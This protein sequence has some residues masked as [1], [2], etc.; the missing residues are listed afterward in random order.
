MRAHLVQAEKEKDQG[1]ERQVK[2]QN[3]DGKW[4]ERDRDQLPAHFR[5][6]SASWCGR[7]AQMAKNDR[8]HDCEI[9]EVSRV[10]DA[11]NMRGP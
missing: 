5:H 1:I 6:Q 9:S 7:I 3:A 10:R 4:R 2:A 8:E 11:A